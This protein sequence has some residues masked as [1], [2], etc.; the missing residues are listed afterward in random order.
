MRHTLKGRSRTQRRECALAH[1]HTCRDRRGSPPPRRLHARRVTGAAGP[2]A[3]GAAGWAGP[4]C[5]PQLSPRRE[6]L[7]TDMAVL[8][9][10]GQVQGEREGSTPGLRIQSLKRCGLPLQS[11]GMKQGLFFPFW[12]L[13]LLP[14]PPHAPGPTACF[15]DLPALAPAQQSLGFRGRSSGARATGGLPPGPTSRRKLGKAVTQT[16]SQ[17]P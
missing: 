5:L 16:H 11:R 12:A 14:P 3:H 10:V 7:G 15:S 2:R 1:P 8:G 13:C 17:T 4:S 6:P 9:S